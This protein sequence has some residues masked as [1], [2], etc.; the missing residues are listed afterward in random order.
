MSNLQ[1]TR[2]A[3]QHMFSYAR[4]LPSI[5]SSIKPYIINESFCLWGMMWFVPS[6]RVRLFSFVNFPVCEIQDGVIQWERAGRLFENRLPEKPI[7]SFCASMS[8]IIWYPVIF[9]LEPSSIITKICFPPFFHKV[10][11]FSIQEE[12]WEL[13]LYLSEV[14]LEGKMPEGLSTGR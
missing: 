4:K 7:S 2:K 13:W 11:R 6:S 5:P 12:E 9:L 10:C 3:W 8:Y 1:L 14:C